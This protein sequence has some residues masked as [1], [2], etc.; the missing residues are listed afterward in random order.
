[1]KKIWKWLL[2]MVVVIVACG[3]VYYFVQQP[4]GHESQPTKVVKKHVRLVA[5]GDSLTYGQ[6]DEKD[7]GGYVGQIKPALEKQY[8]TKVSTWNYGVSGDR[9][10]QILKRLNNQ[11]KMRKN[12]KKAD[13]IV[14][15]VGGN[16]LM[17]KLQGDLLSSK[18]NVSDDV[19]KARTGYEKKLKT[20]FTAVCKQNDHAPIFLFSIYNPVYTYFPQ[21]SVINDSISKWNQTSKDT[22]QNF[23]PAYFVD[24]NHLMSYGQYKTQAKRAQ[25]IK[26]SKQVN[27]TSISQKQVVA[28]MDHREKNLNKYISTEDNFHPNNRGYAQMTKALLK[29]MEK[30]DSFM[31]EKR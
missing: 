23:K 2:L 18:S 22:V 24:I 5:I 3:G 6:G 15:T 17:Q 4:L 19:A 12:L 11:P 28:I 14:M 26:A 21:V 20:L 16:D 8:D 27:Q 13:V 29:Q 31:Y 25:L 7:N 9:S 1:M 30:H 10:D